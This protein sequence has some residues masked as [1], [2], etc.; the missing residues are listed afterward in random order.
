MMPG[1]KHAPKDGQDAAPFTMAEIAEC[2]GWGVVDVHDRIE[3]LA[4]KNMSV[5]PG[6]SDTAKFMLAG[7]KQVQSREWCS[8]VQVGVF[9]SCVGH[10][11]PPYNMALSQDHG[12]PS[13]SFRCALS[14]GQE[15]QNSRCACGTLSRL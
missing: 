6:W 3:E 12:S 15:T 11:T 7:R 14:R 13:L 9:V 4:A 10:K 8:S 5:Q 1:L 2:A